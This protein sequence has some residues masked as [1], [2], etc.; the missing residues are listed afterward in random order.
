MAALMTFTDVPDDVL[1]LIFAK[2]IIDDPRW[3]EELAGVC[4]RFYEPARYL[5]VKRI[6][7]HDF[8]HSS[9][10][11]EAALHWCAN[12]LR[13]EALWRVMALLPN[14][15]RLC[16]RRVWLDEPVDWFPMSA[17]R[18]LDLVDCTLS[19]TVLGCL[20]QAVPNVVRLAIHGG[21][22]KF[23]PST[24][25]PAEEEPSLHHL[26]QALL[27]LHLDTRQALNAVMSLQALY[28]QNSWI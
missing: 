11:P 9:H 18:G 17:L 19:F 22:T 21:E 10:S 8:H 12:F 15:D 28:A 2:A 1:S 27:V 20:L 5:L 6:L 24:D 7:I 25:E 23:V 26:P 16:L 3:T 13:P 4:R 14:M